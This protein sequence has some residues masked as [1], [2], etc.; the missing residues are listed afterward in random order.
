MSTDTCAACGRG[1]FTI[2]AGMSRGIVT[3]AQIWTHGGYGFID[4]QHAAIP[5]NHEYEMRR[6]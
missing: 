4:R 2:N 1:I 6:S 3:L 5:R